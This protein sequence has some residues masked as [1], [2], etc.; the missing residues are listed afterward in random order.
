MMTVNGILDRVSA[1]ASEL[2]LANL[3]PRIAAC[4]R[5]FNGSHGIETSKT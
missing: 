5:Q 2:K 1:L 4:R 3:Q